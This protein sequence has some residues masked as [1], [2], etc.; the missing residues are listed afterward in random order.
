M[1]GELPEVAVGALIFN[2]DGK[3]FLVKSHKWHGKYAIPGGHIELGETAEDALKREIKEETCLDI[4][5]IKFL[6]F[7][8][9]VFDNAYW[10][11]KHFIFLDFA[12][13]TD[14]SEKSEIKLNHEGQGYAWVSVD[15]ALK[16]DVEP[17]TKKTIESYI[18]K[19]RKK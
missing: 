13:R 14:A 8:E 18:E 5:D 11:K 17:Y 7:Q 2:Y 1:A 6:G 9:H 10:K 15:E 16:M 4:H 3:L 19:Y 12:C